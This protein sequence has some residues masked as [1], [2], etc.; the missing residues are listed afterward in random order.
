MRHQWVNRTT[1]ERMIRDGA[2]TDLATIAA[3]SLRDL[4]H[5]HPWAFTV[6]LAG[7]PDWEW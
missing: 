1:F 5:F 4:Y 3:H 7:C 6:E 2:I